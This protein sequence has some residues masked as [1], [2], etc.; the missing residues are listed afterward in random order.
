MIRKIINVDFYKFVNLI[1]IMMIKTI[2]WQRIWPFL[3][4]FFTYLKENLIVKFSW[5]SGFIIKLNTLDFDEP[6][7]RNLI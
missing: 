6:L 2:I 1:S 3:K 4:S 7:V 5:G